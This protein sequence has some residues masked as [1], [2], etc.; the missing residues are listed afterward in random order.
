MSERPLAKRYQQRV[1]ALVEKLTS[2]QYFRAEHVICLDFES[3]YGTGYSL[4]SMTYPE[5]IFD[6]RFKLFGASI[7]I[8][9]GD[10]EY[11]PGDEL[12]GYLADLPCDRSILIGQNLKFDASILAWKFNIIF[13]GYLDLMDM[14][15]LYWPGD[16]A[17]LEAISLRLWPNDDNMWKGKELASFRNKFELTE[18]EHKVMANYCDQDNRITLA[19]VAELFDH[20]PH[21]ELR[22][23]EITLRMYIQPLFHL[24]IPR[25]AAYRDA[26]VAEKK[27]IIKDSG[28]NKTTLSSNPKFAEWM[29]SE[30]IEVPRKINP[31]GAE[32]DALGQKDPAFL[33]MMSDHPEHAKVW[34]ARQAAK[35]TINETRAQRFIDTAEFMGGMLPVPL[36]FYGAHSGRWSGTQKKNMQN[37]PRGGELRKSLMA[38]DGHF[39]YV[40]D[41]S[42]IEARVLAWLAGEEKVLEMLRNGDDLYNDMATKIYGYP[43]FR[44]QEDENGNKVFF[45]EGNVGKTARLGL[46][47]GMGA[48]KFRQTL[49]SGPMGSPPI[50]VS[51]S[52]AQMAVDTFRADNPA[53]VKLWAFLGR[54]LYLMMEHNCDINYGPLR[55]RHNEIWCPDGT[56]LKYPKMRETTGEWPDGRPKEQIICSRGGKTVPLYGGIVT[57]NIVQKLARIIVSDQILAALDHFPDARLALTTHDEGAFIMPQDNAEQRQAELNEIFCR[58]SSWCPDIPLGSEGGFSFNYSK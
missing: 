53:T 9:G 57:E 31:K 39:V 43:V 25:V 38:P 40:V 41:S 24:D 7:S 49:A 4:T 5:Y 28:L 52:F 47:Y 14:A 19:A 3:P 8:D 29:R 6:E 33:A 1:D 45:E 21:D 36:K 50:L 32:T 16:K 17:G 37:L 22:L 46:G 54:M 35:S 13:A 42:N 51:Q 34:E 55:F 48:P 15:N 2:S 20:M 12:E 56:A 30:G 27:Q 23:M 10:T 26:I 18:D 58:P 44:K 11:V